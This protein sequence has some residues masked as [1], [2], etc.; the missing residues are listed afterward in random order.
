L[1]SRG[2]VATKL[3]QISVLIFS[4]C[5]V[6]P[7]WAGSFNFGLGFEFVDATDFDGDD[8]GLGLQLGYEIKETEHWNIGVEL[9]LFD[10]V[11]DE[12]DVTEP[13][14]MAF[15]SQALYIT[16]RPYNWVLQFK[17]GAVRADY[18][19]FTEDVHDIGLA[20]G[21]SLVFGSGKFRFHL[22]DFQHYIVSGDH[23]NSIAASVAILL[24]PLW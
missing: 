3:V 22:L 2:Y 24:A 4:I 8:F 14:C 18:E 17:A 20:C 6:H 12:D 9:D 19:T 11:T 16:A 21:L 10:G 1:R 5:F 23:F 13:Y 15:D 7:V